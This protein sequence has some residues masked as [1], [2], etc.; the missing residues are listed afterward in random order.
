MQKRISNRLDYFYLKC[1]ILKQFS[2]FLVFMFGPNFD[3]L[4]GTKQ[5][6]IFLF[7]YMFSKSLTLIRNFRVSDQSFRLYLGYSKSRI[8]VSKF[9]MVP[10]C[11]KLIINNNAGNATVCTL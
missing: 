1:L 9:H 6:S 11:I 10:L 8:Y 4:L 3:N 7:T 2:V 5:S